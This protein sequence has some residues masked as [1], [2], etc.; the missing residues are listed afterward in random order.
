MTVKFVNI[1]LIILVGIVLV[2]LLAAY[3]LTQP[4]LINPKK[5]DVAIEVSSAQLRNDVEFMVRAFVPRDASYPEN[6]QKMA[7]YLQ[8]RFGETGARV[9]VQEYEINNQKYFNIIASYGPEIGARIVVGAHYDTCCELPGADDNTSGVAGLLALAPLLAKATLKQRIDLVAFTLEEPPYFRTD[10][11][12]SARH[13]RILAEEKVQVDVMI[14]LEMIGYY[15]DEQDTQ[16]YPFNL[17]KLFYPATGNYLAIVG[18]T[19][20]SNI[21]RKIKSRLLAATRLPI[22]SINA[23]AF[24]P[25]VDFSD[26]LNYWNHGFTAVMITDTAFYRNKNY[27]TAGDTPNTL[28]YSRMAEVVRGVY[29]VLIS[30][31]NN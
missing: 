7:K 18:R 15:T 27:H 20:E 9:R 1:F 10:G 16:E 12:G 25:G 4:L 21:T 17:M 6:L 22:Y 26:H 5:V 31:S 19:S 30:T 13:A 14:A 3:S 24:I 23:P 11:M 29:Y 28:D 8:G 2:I